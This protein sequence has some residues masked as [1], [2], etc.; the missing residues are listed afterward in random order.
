MTGTQTRH[1]GFTLI[2]LLVVIAIIAMLAA[3][4]LPALAQAKARAKR[5][6][7]LNNLKQVTLGVKIFST[8]NKS[9]YPWHVYPADGG[10]RPAEYT[11][12]HFLVISNELSTPKI[13]F[14]PSDD[15]QQAAT[16]WT[17]FGNNHVSYF[18]GLD[19]MDNRP[20]GIL[21][22]DRNIYYNNIPLRAAGRAVNGV[23]N[24]TSVNNASFLQSA[25]ASQYS[26][27]AD[28]HQRKGNYSLSD[29]SAKMVN[30]SGLKLDIVQASTGDNNT[31]FDILLPQ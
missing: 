7:C 19:A 1:S 26:W 12:V 14:C 8:D 2:E 20:G 24:K 23:C 21:A 17:D 11:F 5:I 16:N 27:S 18:I 9:D 4:L 31:K 25:L 29:G 6:Q 28:L 30:Q 22:G 3:F 10:S 13:L 15:T